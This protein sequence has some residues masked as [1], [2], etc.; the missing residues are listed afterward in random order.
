[1]KRILYFVLVT[2]L[3][4]VACT[5]KTGERVTSNEAFRKTAPAPGP[6]PKIELGTYDQFQLDNGLKVIV[7]ENHKLPRVSFQ[8]FVDAPEVH[9]GELAG[10]IDMAGGLLNK[11]TTNRT[12]SQIDEA[13]DFMGANLSSSGSGLFA[14]GLSKHT[15]GI[16]DLMA[17]VLMNPT[18]PAEE[19]D[20]LKKQTM[21]GLALSKNDPNAIADN[22]E[23]VLNFGKDHP[24]GNVQSEVSTEKITVD[25]CKAYYQTYFRPN[26]SYLVVVG[27]INPADAK[28]LANKYFGKWEKRAVQPVAYEMP[29][30]PEESRVA[31]V[32]KAG[33]VQSVIH[34]T[35]PID[36]K[37]GAPDAIKASVMNTAL[38]GYFG[39]RL[40]SNLR[41]N[42][43]YTYGARSTIDN[44]P[45]VGYFRAYASVRN[46]VTDSS[47]T[48]FLYELNRL[49]TEKVGDEE[50][51]MVKNYMSGGFARS[52][53]S[54]QTVARFALNT[55][56]F[57]LPQ[58]Y[59][60]TY[61]ERLDTVTAED[62]QAMAQKYL[63]PDKAY[64]LVVG[65]K[66]DVAEKLLPFDKDQKIEFYDTFG[67]PMPEEGMELPK[68]L[69]ADQVV[70]DYITA[71]GGKETVNNVNSLKLAMSADSP[72]GKLE[73]MNLW[74]KPN[75]FM[76]TFGMGGNVM[77][78]MVFDGEKGEM[79]AMGQKQPMDEETLA[80]LKE[81]VFSYF[82]EMNYAEK[83]HK[84]NLVGIEIVEGQ[85]AYRID[86]E[87]PSGKK[88]TQYFLTENSLKVREMED[89][90]GPGQTVTVITDFGDYKKVDG[91]MIP[92]QWTITG[93][94]PIP[95]KM[96]LNTV[97]INGEVDPGLFNIQ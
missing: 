33:A 19:F 66:T 91:V 75:K 2:A 29:N 11:G 3:G 77:Q 48:Q 43:A 55:V 92:H 9:E 84:L 8:L 90:E 68:G 38:G 52:L 69:T 32:D 20:K 30:A 14:S 10:F 94:M 18:F 57:N 35:Y 79:E 59:Y 5:P 6:A 71:L 24:Y 86:V 12:K 64:L 4:F 39:S 88:K 81:D 42:K 70:E 76:N 28:N 36:M 62:V 40:M 73:V 25:V 97:E 22:V 87:S 21:S 80:G 23:N 96:T 93:V 1:M 50:L 58:D 82:G 27:D 45:L 89:Q 74:A 7:V 60:A 95:L 47:M 17:D 51:N 85:K 67:N 56:R 49:R 15:D 31:F 63:H 78:K 46:E 16:L 37:P 26:I 13:V 44:D 61:L 65:N 34:V 41:E 53:E 72:M 54:P 83:G